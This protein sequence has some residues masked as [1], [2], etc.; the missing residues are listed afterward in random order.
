MALLAWDQ[1]YSVG[2]D[3]IDAQH[4]MLFQALNDLHAAMLQ[5]KAREVTGGLLRDLLAYT[6]NHFAAEESMLA[7]D[8]YPDLAQHHQL[9]VDLT[10]QVN[11]Y[12][13]RFERGE[14]AMSVHLIS[15]LSD[16]L[17]HAHPPSGSRLQRLDDAARRAVNAAPRQASLSLECA[18]YKFNFKVSGVILSERGPKRFR[19][20][21]ERS[22]FGAGLGVVSEESA[23]AFAEVS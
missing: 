15:F 16:W 11:D 12:V 18:V 2:I 19:G 9:H 22:L 7:R 20:P 6:R 17:D 10:D 1:S 3:S 8:G 23:F 13:R 21:K 4:N 14:A 5:G